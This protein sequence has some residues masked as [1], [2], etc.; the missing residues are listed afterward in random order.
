MSALLSQVALNFKLILV[1]YLSIKAKVP[2][3]LFNACYNSLAV[4]NLKKVKRTPI[5]FNYILFIFIAYLFNKND[6]VFYKFSDQY[7]AI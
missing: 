7:V 2:R 4:L 3:K 5:A 1:F 6:V